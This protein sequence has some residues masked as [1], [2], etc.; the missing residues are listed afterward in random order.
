MLPEKQPQVL[1]L[2][3]LAQDDSLWWFSRVAQNHHADSLRYS[4]S[5]SSSMGFLALARI[6]S[7]TNWG[8]M[9]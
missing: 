9:S 2:A 5:S 6:L 3:A 1:R 8:T 4:Y 7:A